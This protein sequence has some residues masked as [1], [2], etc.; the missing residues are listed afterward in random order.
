MIRS[1]PLRRCTLLVVA[2][3][4][5]ILAGIAVAAG[6]SVK[7]K[8]PRS[9]AAGASFSAVLSG[10]NSGGND[11]QL[12]EVPGVKG[13]PQTCS[14][15]DIGEGN[16]ETAQ[17]A[18]ELNAWTL[19]AHKSFSKTEPIS[20]AVALKSGKHTLCAYVVHYVPRE[21]TTT[22]AHAIAHYTVKG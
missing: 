1:V 18:E 2:L 11:L 5:L 4:V 10:S 7:L 21:P 9:V 12:Y 6:S 15:T 22:L 13:G 17:H 3:A 16:R 20:A 19:K 8:V 14:S